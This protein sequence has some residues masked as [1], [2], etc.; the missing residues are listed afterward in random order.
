VAGL[1]TLGLAVTPNAIHVKPLAVVGSL[2]TMTGLMAIG[3]GNQSAKRI[4]PIWTHGSPGLA[5]VVDF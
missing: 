4:E 1:V 2:A 3:A 5:L